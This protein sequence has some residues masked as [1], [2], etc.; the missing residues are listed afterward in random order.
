MAGNKAAM[1]LSA[2]M[3]TG[4]EPPMEL[5]VALLEA[6][7]R[8]EGRRGASAGDGCMP[9]WLDSCR[10]HCRNLDEVTVVGLRKLLR[11]LGKLVRDTGLVLPQELC[12]RPIEH[13]LGNGLQDLKFQAGVLSDLASL[14]YRPTDEARGRGTETWVVAWG[15]RSNHR[16]PI[17]AS[18]V[19]ADDSR[20]G[21]AGD[22]AAA[23]VAVRT[24]PG[25][26]RNRLLHRPGCPGAAR[27]LSACRV[28]G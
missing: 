27:V 22:R 9:A 21:L 16:F 17:A 7:N 10:R 19:G 15:S 13:L 28:H 3:L 23:G 11:T 25:P 6:L 26:V 8:Q 20:A 1:L 5:T 2:L 14:G 4:L 24:R 18:S 12:S